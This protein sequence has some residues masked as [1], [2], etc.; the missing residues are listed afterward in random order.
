MTEIDSAD[1]AEEEELHRRPRHHRGELLG[2]QGRLDSDLRIFVSLLAEDS[3]KQMDVTSQK[4]VTESNKVGRW[5]RKP[6]L[7]SLPVLGR[8]C[9][10]QVGAPNEV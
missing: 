6:Q 5:P 3:V 10:S 2:P 4:F 9:E 8:V 7:R 1:I